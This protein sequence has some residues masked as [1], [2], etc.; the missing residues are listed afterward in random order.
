[1]TKAH[2][3]IAHI[4][5]CLMI[6]VC[7]MFVSVVNDDEKQ[8]KKRKTHDTS[9]GYSDTRERPVSTSVSVT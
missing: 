2:E 6:D 4:G 5:S 9:L 1:M 8:N 3:A 7:L